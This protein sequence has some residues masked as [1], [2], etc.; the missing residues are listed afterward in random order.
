MSEIEHATLQ[1]MI[2]FYITDYV[3]RDDLVL[4]IPSIVA[5]KH[6]E[7]VRALSGV[8][9]SFI[10]KGYQKYEIRNLQR[11]IDAVAEESKSQ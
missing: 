7:F 5:E 6:P 11:M 3:S 2:K 9:D 8:I 4:H 1:N 10:K